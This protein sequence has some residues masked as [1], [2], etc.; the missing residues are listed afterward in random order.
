MISFKNVSLAAAAVSS[1]L[2]LCLLF[3]PDL[4]FF[5]FGIEGGE[6][7]RLMSRRAAMLFLG[8]A[9]ISYLG[10][11]APHSV[12]RQAVCMGMAAC[13]AG[14]AIV[15]IFEFV[16]G[17]AGIGIFLAVA[18]EIAFATVFARIWMENAR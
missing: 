14:L 6:V 18:T 2:F 5:I 10:R 16:R 13:M 1:A 11:D 7:A 3:L 4:I 9:T 8:L 15:G 17:F 12:L